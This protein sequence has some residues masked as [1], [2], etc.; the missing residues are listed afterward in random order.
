ML[1]DID[2]NLL[3]SLAALLDEAHVSR[4]A[5]RL[6]VTQSAVSHTLAKLRQHFDDPLLY[7]DKQE[8]R[9]TPFGQSLQAQLTPLLPQIEALFNAQQFNPNQDSHHFCVLVCERLLY[10]S[11]CQWAIQ[12]MQ[13]HP[14]ITVDVA[15]CS[16]HPRAWPKEAHLFV[17]AQAIDNSDAA[18]MLQSDLL[19][20]CKHLSFHTQAQDRFYLCAAAGSVSPSLIE[21]SDSQFFHSESLWLYALQQGHGQ[22]FCSQHYYQQCIERH[23][24][25]AGQFIAQASE[26]VL[27]QQA[28]W[29]MTLEFNQANQWLRGHLEQWWQV[30]IQQSLQHPQQADMPAQPYPERV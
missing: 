19:L 22:A 26:H 17:G 6:G 10:K 20:I 9:L 25:L 11:L 29:P 2:L 8:L 13:S 3:R 12:L 30:Q 23:P 28:F 5:E 24:Q 21:L 27:Q 7:R 14:Q 4:A 1:K 15:Q 16:H 18:M